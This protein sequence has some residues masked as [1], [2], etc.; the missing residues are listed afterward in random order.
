MP[1]LCDS[2]YSTPPP[3]VLEK[4]LVLAKLSL[5]GSDF[6]G[7]PGDGRKLLPTFPYLGS[8]FAGDAE[9]KG[10]PAKF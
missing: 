2:W 6:V 10:S 7:G 1:A 8:P 9:G 3:I 4:P 5:P